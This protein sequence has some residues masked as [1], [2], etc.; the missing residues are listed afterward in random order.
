MK[1]LQPDTLIHNPEGR[2]VVSSVD[3]TSDAGP[4]WALVGNFG[5][6][7]AFIPA[8][9]HIEMIGEGIG[10]LRK[11]HFKDNNLVIEQLNSRD[12]QAMCMTWTTIYNTLGIA[13]LWAGM[14]VETLDNGLCR[15][16]WQIIAQPAQAEAD[17][18]AFDD[19]VQ[20]FADSAMENVRLMFR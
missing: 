2:P 19:F 20:A 3:V 8:L 9:S 10:G 7:D 4:V 14:T 16:T 12:E 13:N 17:R 11:K 5:G 6:F 15:A 1:H 18:V